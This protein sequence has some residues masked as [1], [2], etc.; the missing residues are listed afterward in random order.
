M[1]NKKML[2]VTPYCWFGSAGLLHV[3]LPRDVI[4]EINPFLSYNCVCES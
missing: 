1:N 3:G 4:D 2:T